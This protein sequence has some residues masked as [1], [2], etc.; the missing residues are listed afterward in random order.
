MAGRKWER[1]PSPGRSA[2]PSETG[3]GG[4]VSVL[5]GFGVARYARVVGMVD[6]VATGLAHPLDPLDEIEIR[7]AVAAVKRDARFRGSHR[8]FSVTLLE[9]DKD[10]VGGDVDRQAEVI[11]VDRGDGATEEVTV[12]LAGAEV[13]GWVKLADCHAAYLLGEYMRAVEVVKK[14]E[15]WLAALRAR[16]IDDIER[17][18]HDPWPAGNFGVA[19]EQGRRLVRIVCYV[20]H[21]K[22]DNGYAH[23]IEGLVATFDV[24]TGEILEILDDPEAA[25][26]PSECANYDEAGVGA[27]RTSLKPLDIVQPDAPGFVVEGSAIRWENWRLRVSMHPLDALVLHDV[28]WDDG[29]RLRPILHRASLAEMVVPYGD[30]GIGQR[31]KNAFDSGEIAL[32]RFPFLNSLTLGCDCLGAIHYLD[33]VHVNESG[34]P[35]VSENA[36]CIHEED[37]GIL[38]KHTDQ[39]TFTSEVRRSRRLVVSSFHTVGNYDYGFYWYFY[40]DGT[41]QMEVKLTGILQTK[42]VGELPGELVHSSLVAPGLAAPFHQHLFCFRIDLDV[43]GPSHQ[44]VEEVELVAAPPEME[45]NEFGAAMMLKSTP[46]TTEL[47]A[48]RLADSARSRSWKVVNSGSL[49]RL[50][51]PV[52]YRLVPGL[53]PTLLAGEDSSVAKR[54]RFATHN[55]WVTPYSPTERRAAGYP[56]CAPGEGGLPTFVA[57][58]RSVTDTDVVLWH[59]F[60]VNHVPR[61]E[62]WPVM[63]VEYTGF[64]LVPCGFFDQNPA[65]D[66]P[67]NDRINGHCH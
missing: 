33:A 3:F 8:F 31:W 46:L 5:R 43:D 40:L 14:D 36:V 39:N 22:T 38:W 44:S 62:D 67:P 28:G 16:G 57:G 64:S 23:P 60:G 4:P 58:D 24:T 10:L 59:V 1:G 20:R 2:G 55:L 49:N 53:A 66:V 37:Y 29:E 25:A 7:A 17:V 42:A 51:Q 18:Q 27:W 63:P 19:G 52:A 47:Q 35:Y 45:G 26:I 56:V 9:P 21:H 41:I 54:A 15:R 61:L 34:E 65:L 12:S 13:V 6:A 30:T 32:G 48:R 50:G 11:L